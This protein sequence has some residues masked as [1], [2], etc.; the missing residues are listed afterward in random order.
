MWKVISLTKCRLMSFGTMTQ[1]PSCTC[2]T[3]HQALAPRSAWIPLALLPLESS[4]R[5]HTA[6]RIPL[7]QLRM[8]TTGTPRVKSVKDPSR[9]DLRISCRTCQPLLPPP[10]MAPRRIEAAQQEAGRYKATLMNPPK[11]RPSI[12]VFLSHYKST[13]LSLIPI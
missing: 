4:S 6:S 5:L 2:I 1:I 10:T 8:A 12:C 13:S 9:K 11:A 7:L 3:Y